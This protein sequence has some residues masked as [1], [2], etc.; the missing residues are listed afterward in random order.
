[1]KKKILLIYTGGTIG[2][3]HNPDNGAL[4]PFEFNDIYSHLPML[5][6]LNADIEFKTL[7]PL[8]DSSDTNPAFWVRLATM[9]G[10]NY[11][12]YDGFVILHGT[13]TMSYTASA[14]SFMLEN[15]AKPVI[16]TGSQLP[17]GAVR[18]D[19]RDNIVTAVEIAA[20]ECAGEPRIQD[21]CIYFDN[22]LFRGNRTYK[23]NA[24]E[25]SAFASP[26]YHRLATVGV[27]IHYNDFFI[28]QSEKK[29]LRV[30]KELN[31][32][33]ALLKLFPGISLNMVRSVLSIPGLRGVVM[34][35]FGAGNAPS[36]PE[37]LNLIKEASDRGIII[38]NVSQCKDG[39][40]V[41]MGLYE[42]SVGL[43]KSG[44]ISGGDMTTEAAITKMMY[45]FGTELPDDEIK[46]WLQHTMCGE[47][48]TK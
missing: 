4:E 20:D 45:L 47:M 13:D 44:V 38:L 1:M 34:E 19:G 40:G 39:G 31:D 16:L 2:M 24:E 14:L 37:F 6:L 17:L 7:L 32:N 23:A 25:F 48:T 30:H 35:T 18:T 46:Y 11:K 43:D 29:P 28:H 15:L 42:T 41:K 3:M 33:I 27:T 21:V 26:N 12:A 22:S 9:I 36:D 5:K 8:I 10:E